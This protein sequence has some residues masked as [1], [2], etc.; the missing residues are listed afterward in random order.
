MVHFAAFA[1]IFFAPHR[2]SW[3]GVRSDTSGNGNDSHL[4]R[5]P[6]CSARICWRM[7]R[8]NGV[9]YVAMQQF[10]ICSIVS[11]CHAPADIVAKIQ[12]NLFSIM[13]NFRTECRSY[14]YAAHF[15]VT[16]RRLTMKKQID[17]VAGTVTFTFENG[18][19]PLT[20]RTRDRKSTR[21]NSSHIP[22]SR[23]PSS[24]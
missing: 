23:M 8:C 11:S 17:V 2:P 20:I 13:A 9:E 18:L 6:D 12:Q 22:L 1:K 16:Q 3:V 14:H 24:A 5:M 7:V 21:L 15:N 19:A 4:E 10:K